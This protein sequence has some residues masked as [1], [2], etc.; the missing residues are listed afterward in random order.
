MLMLLTLRFEALQSES[1]GVDDGIRGDSVDI[2]EGNS[3]SGGTDL[4]RLSDI[5]SQADITISDMDDEN[6]TRGATDPDDGAV[7]DVPV[8]DTDLDLEFVPRQYDDLT[9][10]DDDFLNKVIDSGAYQSWRYLKRRSKK[11]N[12]RLEARMLEFLITT[13]FSLLLLFAL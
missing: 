5:G 13:V 12:L 10:K 4:G 2:D 9:A 6:D 8:P 1:E 7:G 3:T 11:R